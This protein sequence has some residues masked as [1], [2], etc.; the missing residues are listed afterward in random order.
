VEDVDGPELDDDA[1]AV[2]CVA[3]PDAAPVVE[4]EVEVELDDPPQSVSSSASEPSPAATVHPLLR[5]TCVS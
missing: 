5:I 2:L 4:P 3:V 1:E